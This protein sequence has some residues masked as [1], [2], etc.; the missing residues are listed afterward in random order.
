MRILTVIAVA[1]GLAACG[2]GPDAPTVK[3]PGAATQGSSSLAV[4]PDAPVPTVPLVEPITAYGRDPIRIGMAQR[5]A[6][7]AL[8]LSVP[9]AGATERETCRIV[10][11]QPNTD[12]VFV[13]LEEGRVTRISVSGASPIRTREGLGFGS[14]AAQ[15]RMIYGA[16]LREAPHP[17]VGGGLSLTW[18]ASEGTAGLRFETDADGRVTAVHGGGPAIA[19]VEGCA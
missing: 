13:M 14:T 11:P 18:W 12:R 7:A 16:E 5:E 1:A 15:V 9:P 10:S 8:G 2:E 6:L 19:Y 17:Y 4:K 3:A